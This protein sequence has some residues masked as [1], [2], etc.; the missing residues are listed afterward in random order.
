MEDRTGGGRLSIIIISNEVVLLLGVI[1]VRHDLCLC[2]VVK[3][4]IVPSVRFVT[5]Q[6][7]HIMNVSHLMERIMINAKH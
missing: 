6:E 4:Q 5:Q 1:S 7:M 3:L 2:V